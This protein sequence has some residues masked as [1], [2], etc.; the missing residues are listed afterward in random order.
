M[1]DLS[2]AGGVDALL[3]FTWLIPHLDCE[4]RITGEPSL[5]KGLVF[6]R[7]A[8]SEAAIAAAITHISAAGLAVVYRD[9]QGDTILQFPGFV[10]NQI[11]LRKDREPKSVYP[12]PTCVDA[13]TLPEH[14][15]Q[16]ADSPPHLSARMLS[17]MLS[18]VE[19]KVEVQ[20][21][22][23]SE[24]KV[25]DI[26]SPRASRAA[27]ESEDANEVLVYYRQRH[28]TR[29]KGIAPGH[30][31]YKLILARL[32]E[33][34]T[35][36]EL[37]LAIDGTAIDSWHVDTR[38][39]SIEYIFR[40]RTKVE[41]FIETATMGNPHALPGFVKGAVR[42]A[43]GESNGYSGVFRNANSNKAL[44]PKPQDGGGGVGDDG[45]GVPRSLP[46]R[47]KQQQADGG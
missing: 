30:K 14:C 11:G 20:G 8:L 16:S 9:G 42:V 3:C 17:R 47:D 41:K 46:S 29:G 24:C 4:G 45:A 2:D 12:E 34:F 40:N 25:Q 18:Q 37:T 27:K 28:P 43:Q 26:L 44:L 33:G 23:E 31:D 35:P 38:N 39:H 1:A 22:V 6:P 15:R 36:G 21:Q 10:K 32:A 13:G 7:A 5:L 19:C